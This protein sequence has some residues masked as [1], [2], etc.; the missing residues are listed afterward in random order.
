MKSVRHYPLVSGFAIAVAGASLAALFPST[1]SENR[2]F[3]STRKRVVYET[4][5]LAVDEAERV[6]AVAS[7]LVD[8]LKADLNRAHR[9]IG[10]A[11]EQAGNPVSGSNGSPLPAR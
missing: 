2:L 6:S 5:G 9:H 8:K 10:E 3:G 7:N 4:R 1:Q 11:A